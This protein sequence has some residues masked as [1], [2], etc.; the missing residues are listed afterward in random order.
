MTGN[1]VTDRVCAHLYPY[2]VIDTDLVSRYVST[3]ALFSNNKKDLKGSNL[4]YAKKLAA[5]NLLKFLRANKR[6]YTEGFIYIISNPAW[7]DKV[8]VGMSVDPLERL[9][10][11][12]TGDP[13][14]AYKLECWAFFSE[15]KSV[16]TYLHKKF[17]LNRLNEWVDLNT[18]SLSLI[19][20][21]VISASLLY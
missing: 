16:E 18:Y 2:S 15:V 6:K 20:E 10:T 11:F 13:Y 4:R 14:R 12:N 3:Y 1:P 5:I 19:K 8:K 21:E 7:P 17:H 9:S